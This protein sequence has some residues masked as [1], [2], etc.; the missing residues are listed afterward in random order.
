MHYAAELYAFLF[1]HIFLWAIKRCD[2]LQDPSGNLHLAHHWGI[3]V[4]PILTKSFWGHLLQVGNAAAQLQCKFWYHWS[5]IYWYYQQNHYYGQGQCVQAHFGRRKLWPVPGEGVG[6]VFYFSVTLRK[7]KYEQQAEGGEGSGLAQGLGSK[8]MENCLTAQSSRDQGQPLF[9]MLPTQTAQRF[10]S[11]PSFW[12]TSMGNS[13][14]KCW[15]FL[16]GFFRC[17]TSGLINWRCW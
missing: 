14:W 1:F 4:I 11:C 15:R 13:S 12:K 3:Q 6:W 5:I 16:Q 17:L 7:C 10:I 2:Y 9:Q 8:M